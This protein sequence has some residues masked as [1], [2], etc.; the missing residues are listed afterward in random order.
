MTCIVAVAEDGVV[1]MGGDSAG[2]AGLNI[3]IRDDPKVFKTHGFI[4]GFTSSFR[5]GQLLQYKFDPPKQTSGTS[6]MKYMVTDFIDAVRKL[7]KENGFGSDS[8]GGNFLVGYNGKL[9]NIDSDYQV[10]IP[11]DKYDSVGCGAK[12]ALGSLYST[13]GQKP[14]ARLKASLEA[15]AKFNAGV[16]A[17]FV[18][19]S[20]KEVFENKNEKSKKSKKSRK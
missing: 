3:T 7:F 17:P 14:E 20:E 11:S 4:M 9:Y 19:M 2:V 6:D 13:V 5:M 1:Y 8:T 10:G 18:I 15:A 16:S 12:I